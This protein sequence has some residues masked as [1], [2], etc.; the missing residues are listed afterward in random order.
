MD[1][2]RLLVRD[3][4]AK[5]RRLVAD[6]VARLDALDAEGISRLLTPLATDERPEVR[7]RAAEALAA[8]LRGRDP[9]EAA[10]LLCEW[11]LSDDGVLRAAASVA[12]RTARARGGLGAHSDDLGP[13][14]SLTEELLLPTELRDPGAP[15]PP[16]DPGPRG[17]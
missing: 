11:A 13:A 17:R 14:E 6:A 9:L 3:R 15:E 7:S 4:R 2:L 8:Q 10:W 16:E 12:H 1:L 5:V